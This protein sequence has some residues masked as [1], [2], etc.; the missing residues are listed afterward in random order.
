VGLTGGA[1]AGKSTV[2]H[3]LRE[4]GAV[5]IDA[6]VLAREVLE[7]G[8][9]GLCE[10]V[11]AFGERVLLDDGRLDRG[12]LADVVFADPEQRVRLEKITHPRIAARTS[13]IL[14]NV[15]VDAVVVHDVPLLV[16]KAMSP[17]YD[18]V[19]VVDAPVEQRVERLVRRG[20]TEHDARARIATQATREQREAVADVWLENDGSPD[21]L[22]AKV[23]QLWQDRLAAR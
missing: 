13:E 16:E 4:L 2:A 23:D 9:E 12:A 8:S 1:G 14:A 17:A 18:L 6:D 19:V 20:M 5:V 15:P 11:E 7:P 22:S 3:R 21:E 10:V